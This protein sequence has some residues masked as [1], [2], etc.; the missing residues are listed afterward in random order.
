MEFLGTRFPVSVPYLSIHTSS[1]LDSHLANIFLSCLKLHSCPSL[2]NS[3]LGRFHFL[4]GSFHICHFI[5]CYLLPVTFAPEGALPG[6]KECLTRPCSV[7][8]LDL[9]TLQT[10]SGSINKHWVCSLISPT[11][12]KAWILYKLPQTEFKVTEYYRIWNRA[13]RFY[14]SFSNK[15]SRTLTSKNYLLIQ[16][17]MFDDVTLTLY[18]ELLSRA[19]LIVR[20]SLCKDTHGLS[21]KQKGNSLLRRQKKRTLSGEITHR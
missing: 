12:Q 3:P 9:S 19:K 20:A 18:P 1:S 16:F 14:H 15:V 8:I 7:H 13:N 5:T 21:K 2:P 6:K 4:G 10:C 11:H 17:S